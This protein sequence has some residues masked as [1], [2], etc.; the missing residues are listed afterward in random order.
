MVFHPE[1]TGLLD[2]GAFYA[3][4]TQLD[5]QGQRILWGWIQERRSEDA[6]RAAGWSGMMSLPRVLSLDQDGSLRI[7]ATRQSKALRGDGLPQLESL[8][9][10]RKILPQASGEVMCV[11]LR[12]KA[13]EFQMSDGEKMLMQVRYS[14]D[15]HKFVV[16]GKE[17]GL[18][19]D[20]VPKVHAYVDGSVIEVLLSE[21]IGYTKR[22][23]YTSAVAPD[24]SVSVTGAQGVT[25]DAWKM[26]PISKN[27]LTTSA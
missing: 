24:I 13:F 4:K 21:R 11:G 23:Y 25:L 1:K 6:M 26:L 3:P 12:G 16:D 9:G 22:F 27:R 8:A 2:L 10:V 14:P 5:A 7:T 20:D 18:Q 15:G 17:F 19:P